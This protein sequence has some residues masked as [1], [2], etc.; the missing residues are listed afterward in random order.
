MERGKTM[1]EDQK[2]LLQIIEDFKRPEI[3]TIEACLNIIS[4]KSLQIKKQ[5]ERIE[6]LEKALKNIK[7]LTEEYL[8]V[9]SNPGS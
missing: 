4:N 3:S 9:S 7:G 6:F 1:N 8:R 2:A 5:A